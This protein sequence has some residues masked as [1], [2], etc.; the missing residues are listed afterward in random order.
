[1]PRER[2]LITVKTYPALSKKYG[3]TVCTAGLR[4][5]GS[6]MRIY[7]V[8]FR[9]LDEEQQY[10]KYDWIEGDFVRNTHDHRH[11]TFRPVDVNNITVA[12]KMG[13]ANGW[14]ERKALVLGKTRVETRLTPLCKATK[15]APK[16]SASLAVFKPAKLLDFYWESDDREWDRERL[17]EMQDKARQ[18]EFD[19]A[20]ADAWRLI[21]EIIDKLPYKFFY[22][23]EDADNRVSCL[24]LLDW[25][26]GQL[27]WN[28]F[29]RTDEKL[30]LV[31][32]ENEALEKVRQKYWDDFLRKDTHFFIGTLQQYHGLSD[33]PWNIIGVFYPPH[34]DQLELGL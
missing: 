19:F 25:E 29:R 30:G 10:G 4:E 16:T 18:S 22:K 28:C 23:F 7:P 21:F 20:Q 13:T 24:Q 1:M 14:R 34:M 27:F 32:R 15:D 9:R 11:E 31:E 2:I 3:E 17:A 5:D 26:C 12:G 33:T 8:P 6:W